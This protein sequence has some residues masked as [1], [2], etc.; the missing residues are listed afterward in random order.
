MHVFLFKTGIADVSLSK[1]DLV[2]KRAL[3]KQK[4]KDLEEFYKRRTE[5]TEGLSEQEKKK[6]EEVYKNAK[7]KIEELENKC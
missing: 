2:A 4:K 5:Q 1:S 7:E 6:I 3:L